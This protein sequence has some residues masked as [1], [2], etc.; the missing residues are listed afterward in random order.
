MKKNYYIENQ[1][2][3]WVKTERKIMRKNNEFSVKKWKNLIIE[4]IYTKTAIFKG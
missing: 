2:E 3:I 1:K 4:G